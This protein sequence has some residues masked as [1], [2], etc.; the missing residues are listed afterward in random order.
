M[1]LPSDLRL[2]QAT[3]R[4]G[5]WLPVLRLL[6]PLGW[7]LAAV[8]YYGPWVAHPTAALTLSGPDMGEFVKFL[9]PVRD[10]SL[11]LARQLFYLPAV[12][13][14]IA[15]ALSAWSRALG[16]RWPLRWLFLAA[17]VPVSLQLLPPAWSPGILLTPE[18]R[19]QTLTLGVC[20]LLLALSWAL[21]RLPPWIAGG[22]SAA[23]ALAAAA[24]PAWQFVLAKPAI[25]AVY[26]TPP[27][28]GWGF[29]LGLVGL[30]VT[31]TASIGLMWWAMRGESKLWRSG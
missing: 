4:R 30:V 26:G 22:I 25:E 3:Q 2:A 8:G 9:P 19:L 11:Q 21:G 24:L 31:S 6:L 7:A 27:S 13:V 23:L 15:I 5:S 29:F 18:F 20:W 28:T 10:G 14:S 12:A 16:Y 17:A 1:T